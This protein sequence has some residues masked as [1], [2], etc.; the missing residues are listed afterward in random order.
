MLI[1]RTLIA[2]VVISAGVT[3][4]AIAN[5]D[6]SAGAGQGMDMM[7]Q[8]GGPGSMGMGSDAAMMDM[9]Q[10]MMRMHQS[11]MGGD[12]QMGMMSGGDRMG[13]M[14]NDMMDMMMP[15]GDPENMAPHMEVKLEEFD[16]NADGA[17]TLQE[18]AAL[19]TNAVR[20]RMVDRFQHLDADAD[21]QVTQQEMQAAGQRIGA[22]RQAPAGGAADHHGNDN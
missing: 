19:H 11:M 3:Q 7:T 17:L 2:A 20:D 15:G 5:E 12:G 9:M 14:D 18:F 21:G 22:M 6:N 8:S 16:A 10:M 4:A 1:R 13:M